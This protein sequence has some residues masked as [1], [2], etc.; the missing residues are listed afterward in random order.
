MNEE[1]KVKIN[2]FSLKTIK[3]SYKKVADI[4]NLQ[5]DSSKSIDEN[6]IKIEEVRSSSH[7]VSADFSHNRLIFGAPGTGKSFKV[8]EEKIQLLGASSEGYFER[9]TFHPEYSYSQFVGTYKP[10]SDALS[11]IEYKY[12]P[13]PF[14]RL[15]VKAL[16]NKL[17]A[18]SQD[19]IKPYLLVIEEINR[20]NVAAVFGEV[21]Q[22]LDRDTENNSEYS[23]HT[24]ED[25]RAYLSEELGGRMDEIIIPNNMYIWGTMNSADQ[26]VFPMDT[27]FKRRWNFTY[28]DIDENEDDTLQTNIDFIQNKPIKWNMLRKAINIQLLTYKVNEDK[29]LGPYFISKS[30]LEKADTFSEENPQKLDEEFKNIF[31]NKVLTYLYEDAAK[32]KKLSLFSPCID[33]ETENVTFS[34][35]CKKFDEK[36]IEIFCDKIQNYL[37]DTVATGGNS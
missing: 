37:R 26:G 18:T 11:N 6:R 19:D 12:V 2:E 21:F 29:L 13:G 8:N 16:K 3:E 15:L 31:K 1:N 27:A 33:N 7:V 36:G 34:D 28:V 30:Q 35:I 10:V 32:Q 5:D 20:A 22:L 25:M 24:S 4:L 14:L 9:V 23:I 17:E